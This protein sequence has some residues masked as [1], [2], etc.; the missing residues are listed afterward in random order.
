MLERTSKLFHPTEV[1]YTP[2]LF[3]WKSAL[4][5]L[6]DHPWFGTG[7]DT[8]Q[9]S[10]PPY[11]E[12]IYWN[13]EW[14]GTPEKA[15]NFI[16][17]TAATMGGLELLAFFWMHA[18]WVLSSFRDWRRQLDE[19]RRMLFDLDMAIRS[20]RSDKS[21][22]SVCFVASVSCEKSIL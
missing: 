6:R 13:L 15:H 4:A 2:R 19:R 3:I 12:A 16:M 7:L 5:M 11:R 21:N 17:Q 1:K 18:A 8:F 10:F 20:Q 9:I 14:N 22:G